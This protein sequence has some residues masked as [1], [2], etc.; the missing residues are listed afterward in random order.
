[1]L[2]VSSLLYSHKQSVSSSLF[3]IS[4]LLT[5]NKQ[6]NKPLLLPLSAVSNIIF[7]LHS[8]FKSSVS[9]S[10]HSKSKSR[11]SKLTTPQEYGS[12][13]Q[14]TTEKWSRIPVLCQ[15]G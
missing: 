12:N 10:S 11:A 3:T 13:N 6:R 14:Y 15:V 8:F 4:F 5:T 9:L 1:M 7:S 2:F